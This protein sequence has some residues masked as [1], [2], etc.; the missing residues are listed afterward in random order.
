MILSAPERS[1]RYAALLGGGSNPPGPGRPERP[2]PGW[3]GAEDLLLTQQVFEPSVRR[4]FC[5]GE[6][7]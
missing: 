1:R 3:G 7:V 4:E 2:L 6:A 5:G